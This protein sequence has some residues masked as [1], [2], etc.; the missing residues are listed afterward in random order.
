MPRDLKADLRHLN[1]LAFRRRAHC[2]PL[3][4]RFHALAPKISALPAPLPGQLW[5]IY[6]WLLVPFMLWPHDF[7]GLARDLLQKLPRAKN[8]NEIKNKIPNLDERFYLLLQ[9]IGEPPAEKTQK[10]IAEFERDVESG[11]Y[12]EM[13]KQ[14][15]KYDEAER[16][17]LNDEELLAAWQSIK[18]NFDVTKY[19]N[20]RGVIR[21]R[22][23]GER[24]FRE[25]WNFDWSDERNQFQTIFDA[26]CYRW[27]LYGMEHD[28]PLLLKISVNPTPHGTMILIP[29]HWSLDPRRDLDW[30]LINLLHRSRGAKKQGPKMSTGRIQKMGDAQKVKRLW[31]SGRKKGLKGERLHEYIC[32][33]MKREIRSD[34]SWWKR[35]LR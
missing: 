18:E 9:S 31:N 2:G 11:R 33:N 26:L 25:N 19:Q 12:D 6:D 13:L 21:R 24:N 7:E 8:E 35:L 3:L 30:S 16:A 23:S 20:R 28:R 5:N 10:K 4:E 17:L 27:N 29:R 34:P 22:V 32:V 14:R 15:E 1:T